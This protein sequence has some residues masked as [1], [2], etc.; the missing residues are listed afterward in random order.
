MSAPTPG[1]GDPA[2][3]YGKLT[4][5]VNAFLGYRPTSAELEEFPFDIYRFIIRSIRDRDQKAT[6]LLERFLL[7]PEEVWFNLHKAGSKLNTLYDAEEIEEPYLRSLARLVGFGNDLIDIVGTATEEQ[8]RRI[9]A[10]AIEFWRKRWL[11]SGIEAAIRMSTG[12]RF[13]VR[14]YFD[15][16]FIVGENGIEEDLRN[17]DPNMISV[18]T[19]NFFRSGFDGESRYGADPYTFH[20]SSQ[21][22]KSD[23]IGGYIVIFDDTGSPTLNGFY[24]VVDVDISAGLWYVDVGDWFPRAETGLSWFIAFPYDEFLTEIRVVDEKTGQGEVDRTFLEKLLGQQRPNGERFNVVYVD[25]M[26]LFQT[27]N[28]LG[29][30]EELQSTDLPLVTKTV[31]DGKLVLQST[32]G[33]PILAD[34]FME[35]GPGPENLIDGDMEAAGTAA[36]TAIN[37]ATLTKDVTFPQDGIQCLRVAYNGTGWPMASQYVKTIG[38]TYVVSGYARGNGAVAP[39]VRDGSTVIWTGTSS[40][41]W[42]QFSVVHYATSTQAQFGTLAVSAGYVEFDNLS[43]RETCPEWIAVNNPLLTKE[44]NQYEGQQCF[45]NAY[46]G[47]SF[48]TA[49]QQVLTPLETYRVWG[50]ARGDGTWLPRVYIG[51]SG[52]PDWSGTISGSWQFLDV[53]AS[54]PDANFQLSNNATAAGY[55]EFDALFITTGGGWIAGVECTRPTADWENFQWKV[56]AAIASTPGSLYCRFLNYDLDNS[57]QLSVDYY[58]FGH[59]RV[60]LQTIKSGVVTTVADWMHPSLSPETYWTYTIETYTLPSGDVNVRILVDGNVV[61]D[62]TVTPNYTSGNIVLGCGYESTVWI[63]ET[64]LWVYPLDISRVG[65]NP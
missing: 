12:N 60:S 54:T 64:E 27:P 29:Q 61:I 36:W 14:D 59:G 49:R 6:K 4:P 48:P 21:A 31:A 45:R 33:T 7:G 47:T 34:G 56:K 58:G 26:D 32:G 62:E 8:L 1:I 52:G 40:T 42:Q 37:N 25:F 43:V 18:K 38:R 30:W 51:S 19:R 35:A 65:P 17:T 10:G 50:V 24:E 20:S 23:D 44:A 46:N 28:D 22:P 11:D 15:F 16:R 39:V 63:E 3:Q 13:K 2:Y 53:T 55:A 9:I 5:L 57:L 41:A